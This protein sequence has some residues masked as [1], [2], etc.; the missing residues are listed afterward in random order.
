MREFIENLLKEKSENKRNSILY[1]QWQL[2]KEYIPQ[3]LNLIAHSFP[4]YS[5]HDKSHSDTILNNI[6]RIVG[7]DIIRQHFSALDLWMLLSVAYYHDIGMMIPA[8]QKRSVIE[9]VNFVDFVLEIQQQKNSP[10]YEYSQLF[11]VQE[12]VLYY[13]NNE[14]NAESY[15]SARYLIAEFVRQTHAQRSKEIISHHPTIE[16]PGSPIPQRIIDILG[17]ICHAHTQSFDCVMN[18]PF[19]QVGVDD[20]DCHPRY[21]ACLLRL[22]DLLDLDT[23]RFSE[24]LL[25]TLGSIPVDSL[26]HKA[27][28][29]SIK[30]VRIDKQLISIA[31]LCKSYEVADL[32]SRWFQ[33]LDEEMSNQM[34]RWNDI[35]PTSEY[36]FLPTVG[37]LKVELEDYDTI[38]GKLRPSFQIDN[39]KSIE[40]LQGAGLYKEA[41]QCMR[42]L[43]QNAVDAT[44]LRLYK[45]NKSC[46]K[47][48]FQE[49][50]KQQPIR[51]NLSHRDK[52]GEEQKIIWKIE[53][54][55][56]GIGMSKEDLLYLTQTGS[57]SKNKSKTKIINEMP[58]WMKPS[59]T[60]GIG[61]Q[62]VFLLADKVTMIT[63]K[64]YK[65][66]SFEVELNNPAGAR[67]GVVLIKSKIDENIPFGTSVSFERCVEKSPDS[68]SVKSEQ[69]VTYQIINSF[70]FVEDDSMDIEMG[71]I[72]D[73]IIKFNEASY[74]PVQLFIDGEDFGLSKQNQIDFEYYC[75]EQGLELSLLD[76]QYR[77]RVYY[78]GQAVNHNLIIRYLPTRINIVGG[79][80]K[81][82]VTLN[83]NEIRSEYKHKLWCDIRD[84]IFCYLQKQYA[85]LEPEV[86]QKASMFIEYYRTEESSNLF[87]GIAVDDWKQY[88]VSIHENDDKNKQSL[89]CIFNT[90]DTIRFVRADHIITALEDFKIRGVNQELTIEYGDANDIVDFIKLISKYH[91]PYISF[92]RFEDTNRKM[93]V[94]SKKPVDD[95]IMDMEFWLKYYFQDRYYAR[96]FMPCNKQY[97]ILEVHMNNQRLYDWGVDRTFHGC[98]RDYPVMICPYIVKYEQGAFMPYPIS[99]KQSVSD[100][101]IQLT[102]QHRVDKEVT[103]EQIKKTY[104]QF[105][106]D[107]EQYVAQINDNVKKRKD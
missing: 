34:R 10:L 49:I 36:G 107:T 29:L 53:I 85:N 33:F 26:F 61:F 7:A 27:K 86:K 71:K 41:Y 76:S 73:E 68:W 106:Q 94:V 24:V 17:S 18:L 74:I 93:I 95:I 35:V 14:L 84:S 16:L 45:D 3:E 99:M 19:S 11:Q 64:L 25:N 75:P 79:N 67:D 91:F 87:N 2:A 104:S 20:E 69:E 96:T 81:D 90:Y 78:R 70:D 52:E 100:K 13:R 4:H 47:E 57:S 37:D 103:I 30:S 65:E 43:L 56:Q 28:H 51:V 1:T 44:L 9:D 39:K 92:Q 50:C 54:I 15:E 98:R 66:Q 83:R 89:G 46:Q 60:F 48:N 55:D 38:D 82:V 8:E 12:K 40:L 77:M 63:K 62:S 59:G 42:E 6:T 31:A 97:K 23:N 5:L 88:K 101:L 72:V 58:E 102:F 22:G 21:I 80:A 105:I 32:T